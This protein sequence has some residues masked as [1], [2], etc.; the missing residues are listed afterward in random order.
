MKSQKGVTLLNLIIVIVIIILG[1]ILV[2]NLFN[3]RTGISTELL[4]SEV[5][6]RITTE[7]RQ[8]GVTFTVLEDMILVK[9]NDNEYS[10]SIKIMYEGKEIL[11]S[12]TVLYDGNYIN[13]QPN[14][15]DLFLQFL[16]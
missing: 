4:A 8:K 9:K 7:W 11:I 6:E 1:I 10:G 12:G 13:W 14:T 15:Q 5:Q 16:Y 2:S 3:D